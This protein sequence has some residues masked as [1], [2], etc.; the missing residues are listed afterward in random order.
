MHCDGICCELS[1]WLVLYSFNLVKTVNRVELVDLVKMGGIG[2]L[3]NIG[4]IGGVTNYMASS[5]IP[6]LHYTTE[7]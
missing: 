5:S 6:I 7:N 3:G 1:S 4:G 2:G